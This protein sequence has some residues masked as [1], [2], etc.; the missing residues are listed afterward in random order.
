MNN[1]ERERIIEEALAQAHGKHKYNLSR[2]QVRQVLNALFLIGAAVGIVVY[3]AL[4]LYSVYGLCIIFVAMLLKM[5]E[6]FIRF[7]L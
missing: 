5:V 6:F 7:M 2:E 4:P 3:F 1:E